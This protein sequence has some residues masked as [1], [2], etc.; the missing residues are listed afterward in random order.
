MLNTRSSRSS[1]D[2]AADGS[3]DHGLDSLPRFGEA[4]D[5]LLARRP[6]PAGDGRGLPAAWFATP[7]GPVVAAARP[8]GL[9]FLEFSHRERLEGQLARL[10]ERFAGP[11]VSGESEPLGVLRRELEEY[12]AGRRRVFTVPLVYPGTPF[13]VK[14]WDTLRTIP[15]GETLSYT[16]VARAIGAFRAVRAVGHANGRNPISIVIPCHRVV[17]R[18]GRLG[19]YGG[20]LWRKERLLALEQ[21]Q[22]V[23]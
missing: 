16:E 14:V 19:G 10:E 15:Y 7:L 3:T 8:E 18:G 4:W 22:T 20:G 1:R 6:A 2:R 12:F 21:G 9:C 17:N 11:V 5:R 23:L 13:Q